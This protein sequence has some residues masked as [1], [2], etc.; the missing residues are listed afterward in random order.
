MV[1]GVRLQCV[2]LLLLHTPDIGWLQSYERYHGF[3]IL[4]HD[5]VSCKIGAL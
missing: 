5:L 1:S 2:V 3:G 4:F